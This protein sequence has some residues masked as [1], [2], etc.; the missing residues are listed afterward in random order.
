MFPLRHSAMRCILAALLSALSS[1]CSMADSPYVFTSLGV[2]FYPYRISE[3]GQVVGAGEFGRN[4]ALL[5]HDGVVETL[6]PGAAHAINN[7]G[8]IVIS[9]PRPGDG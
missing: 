4:P 3:S 9:A 5:W 8:D 1:S 6:G 7:A 2:D